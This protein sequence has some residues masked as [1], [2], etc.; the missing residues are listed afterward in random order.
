[1][2]L[3]RKRQRL[4][5]LIWSSRSSIPVADPIGHCHLPSRICGKHPIG[6][7]VD[8]AHSTCVTPHSHPGSGRMTQ[9]GRNAKPA[10]RRLQSSTS[11]SSGGR[12]P[13]ENILRVSTR[14]P[15]PGRLSLNDQT[16]DRSSSVCLFVSDGT[17]TMDRA[18][19]RSRNYPSR[20]RLAARCRAIQ[21]QR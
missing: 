2:V 8:H 17:E 9:V 16:M 19:V 3:D 13:S 12:Y 20:E 1:M 14:P 6:S 21:G 18:H 10:Q 5:L 15:I 7:M 4:P 11:V